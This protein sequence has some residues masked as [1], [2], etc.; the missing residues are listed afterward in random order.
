MM[1]SKKKK[2]E[3]FLQI[4]VHTD[5]KS[6]KDAIFQQKNPKINPFVVKLL[7]ESK[8]TRFRKSE[9]REN[10]NLEP[11]TPLKELIPMRQLYPSIQ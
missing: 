6:T 9:I 10:F 5:M 8:S 1:S 2:I 4:S 7:L 11:E 3:H